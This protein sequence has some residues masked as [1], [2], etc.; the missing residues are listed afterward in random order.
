MPEF[1]LDIVTPERTAYTGVVESLRAPGTAGG[2]GVLPRHAPM[3]AA[4]AAGPVAFVADGARQ[5]MAISGGF[6]EILGDS[7][8]VL[9]ET[10]ER[11]DE[12]DIARAQAARDRAR[13]RLRQRESDTERARASLMRAINRLRVAGGS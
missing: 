7:V 1:K 10:A 9:A 5:E 2:F 4:L 8:T 6:A 13:D 12:I 11:P 3:L